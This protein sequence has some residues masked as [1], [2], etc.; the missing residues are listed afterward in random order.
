VDAIVTGGTQTANRL[1]RNNPHIVRVR[2][3]RKYH[4]TLLH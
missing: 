3:R 1:L 4:S 2:S